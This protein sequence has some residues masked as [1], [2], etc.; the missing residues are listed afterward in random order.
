[1]HDDRREGF[2]APPFPLSVLIVA[3][4]IRSR[5][6]TLMCWLTA[7]MSRMVTEIP[8]MIVAVGMPVVVVMPSL[9]APPSPRTEGTRAAAR[10]RKDLRDAGDEETEEG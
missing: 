5:S 4:G 7:M 9:L 3:T 10:G 8:V 2:D 6:P 1:M